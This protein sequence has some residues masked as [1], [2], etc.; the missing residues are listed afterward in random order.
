MTLLTSISEALEKAIQA[1]QVVGQCSLQ[2]PTLT[3]ILIKQN[4]LDDRHERLGK[5]VD[6]KIQRRPHVDMKKFQGAGYVD[7][8]VQVVVGHNI[9]TSNLRVGLT[10]NNWRLVDIYKT[11]GFVSVDPRNRRG[12]QVKK[13]TVVQEWRRIDDVDDGIRPNALW[14]DPAT[15]AA[16]SAEK[17]ALP[18]IKVLAPEVL[19]LVR[20]LNNRRKWKNCFVWLNPPGLYPST[21]PT[22]LEEQK[23]SI[24]TINLRGPSWDQ[25]AEEAATSLVVH[26]HQ[27]MVIDNLPPG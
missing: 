22:K 26:D 20:E 5:E 27:L 6:E 17:D 3:Q 11:E 1:K 19:D 2:D 4:F 13:I 21:D 25:E 10:N 15:L 9:R 23:N 24:L 14:M 7:R 8:G 16:K 18:K 12:P